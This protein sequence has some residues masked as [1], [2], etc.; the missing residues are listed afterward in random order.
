M[1]KKYCII[2]SS[3]A[4]ISAANVLARKAADDQVIII[5]REQQVPYNKCFL[6]DYARADKAGEDIAILTPERA[7]EL[8]IQLHTGTSVIQIDTEN[9]IIS[10]DGDQTF[11]YDAL[12]YATGASVRIPPIPGLSSIN[13][14]MTFH[15]YADIERLQALIDQQQ[16]KH[17]VVVGAGLSGLECADALAHRGIAVTVLDHALHILSGQISVSSAAYIVDS[18]LQ[19]GVT[20]RTNTAINAVEYISDTETRVQL[21]TGEWVSTNLMVFATGVRPNSALLQYA[22]AALVDGYVAVDQ[23]MHTSLSGIYAAGDCV[24]VPHAITG[25]LVPSTTWPDAMQQGRIAAHNMMGMEQKYAGIMPIMSSSFFG[26]KYASSGYE[27]ADDG[28]TITIDR[29]DQYSSLVVIDQMLRGFVQVGKQLSLP[30]LRRALL[31]QQMV[32]KEQ[33]IDLLT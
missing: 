24:Q 2:G 13:N 22:G 23:Y 27:L 6:A 14:Y 32:E 25:K 20:I 17:V 16:L 15:T 7:R 31:T 1:K 9:K 28:N 4:G 19:H 3:A 33:I 18:A 26:V 5:T 8:N 12:M 11:S 30:S 29:P 10:T 21:S